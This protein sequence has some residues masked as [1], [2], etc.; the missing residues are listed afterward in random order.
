[1]PV[2]NRD[3][4]RLGVG[5][6]STFP[7]PSTIGVIPHIVDDAAPWPAEVQAIADAFTKEDVLPDYVRKVCTCLLLC[8]VRC[9][10]LPSYDDSSHRIP[11]HRTALYT[12]NYPIPDTLY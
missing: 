6:F 10:T 8:S 1:M 5:V 11:C 2:L 9:L 4:E 12:L 3:T 7:Q